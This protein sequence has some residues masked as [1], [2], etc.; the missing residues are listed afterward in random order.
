L[1]KEGVELTQANLGDVV[2]TAATDASGKVVPMTTRDCNEDGKLDLLIPWSEGD[3]APMADINVKA[4]CGDG[5]L[6]TAV[7]VAL[8]TKNARLHAF[9]SAGIE[10][11]VAVAAPVFTLQALTVTHAGGIAHVAI[12]GS[13]TCLVGVCWRCGV[14]PTITHG[15]LRGDSNQDRT[16]DLSD[17]VATLNHLFSGGPAPRCMDA[18]DANDDG[19]FDISDPT[20]TLGFLFLGA[21]PLPGGPR[22][23]VDGTEDR[24]GCGSSAC[25]S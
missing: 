8:V 20:A 22:C 4:V 25:E 18:A 14:K 9:D 12:E 3:A 15:F 21:K 24:L 16:V 6:P 19:N 1:E 2:V 23:N 7:V 13:E 5:L 10:V 17:A 11:D